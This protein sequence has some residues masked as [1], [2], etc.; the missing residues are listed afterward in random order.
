MGGWASTG[1]VF[2]LSHSWSSKLT[3]TKWYN[4]QEGPR[5]SVSML[6]ARDISGT[7]HTD[8]P[9]E[10]RASHTKKK[11]VDGDGRFKQQSYTCL[12]DLPGNTHITKHTG[13]DASYVRN[14]V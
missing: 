7:Q 9:S 6:T 3:E 12:N 10:V 14:R 5:L 2:P 13:N 4:R 1:S 11:M 8:G